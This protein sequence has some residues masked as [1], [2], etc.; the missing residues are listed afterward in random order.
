MSDPVGR[1]LLLELLFVVLGAFCSLIFYAVGECSES[2]WIRAAEDGDKKA[3]RLLPVI[4]KPEAFRSAMRMGAMIFGFFAVMNPMTRSL[5]DR[6]SGLVTAGEPWP[7]LAGGLVWVLLILL[8]VILMDMAP[9]RYAWYRADQVLRRLFTPARWL[10][11]ALHPLCWVLLAAAGGIV[12][13]LGVNPKAQ[14]EEVSEDE[15]LLLVDAGGES[16]AIGRE[17]KELIEKVFEFD[18]TTA[19]DIMVHRTDVEMIWLDDTEEE[20]LK[21]IQESGLSRFPVCGEDADDIVG[22]LSTREYL[23]ERQKPQPRP[24]KEL[25]RPAFF[26]PESVKADVLFRDMQRKKVHMALVVDE[27]GGTA[28]LITMEDLLEQL[29]GEIYDEFDQEEEQEITQLEDG[30]WRIAGAAALEDVLEALE[31]SPDPEEVEE[32]ETLG[33]LVF[34]Q[35]SV[36][37][38]DGARPAVDAMGMHIQVESIA[39]HRVEWALVNRLPPPAPPAEDSED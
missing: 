26:V 1:W 33:G 15:I 17:E 24:L 32:Y 27:Y 35:L 8:S 12:R 4:Q 11:R 14:P 19:E 3:A 29:V 9:E 34:G 21:T 39:D 5:A 10:E 30:L 7:R 38:Q 22:V 36:I 6:V 28:G 13:L 23:L 25:L 31:L 18:D 2:K 16:G 20:I 37:P